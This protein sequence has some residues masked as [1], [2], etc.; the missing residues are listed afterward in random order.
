M[1]SDRSEC[2]SSTVFLT[3]E[4]PMSK[5]KRS[6]ESGYSMRKSKILTVEACSK[7]PRLDDFLKPKPVS[8]QSGIRNEYAEPPGNLLKD[9]QGETETFEGIEGTS[10]NLVSTDS[11]SSC[12]NVIPK[13]AIVRGP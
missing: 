5:M 2:V 10:S 3:V 11:L 1:W 4:L 9:L 8:S 13:D 7:L 6:H 12:L